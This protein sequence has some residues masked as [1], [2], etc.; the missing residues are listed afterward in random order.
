MNI[1]RKGGIIT[2][3]HDGYETGDIVKINNVEGTIFKFTGITEFRPLTM[4]N[5]RVPVNRAERR[6]MYAERRKKKP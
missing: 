5:G 3:A 1:E 2:T 6:K 4:K